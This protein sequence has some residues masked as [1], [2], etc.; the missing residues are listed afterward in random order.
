[1]STTCAI[2]YQGIQTHRFILN[3]TY[4]FIVACLLNVYI[5]SSKRLTSITGPPRFANS[6]AN[7]GLF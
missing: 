4:T 2:T 6:S 1:M 7:L 5:D 3:Y